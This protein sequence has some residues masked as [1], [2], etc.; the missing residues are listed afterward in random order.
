MLKKE[1]REM[2]V[3]KEDSGGMA[4]PEMERLL[5]QVWPFCSNLKSM[6]I[7]GSSSLKKMVKI[8]VAG[9]GRKEAR[10]GNWKCKGGRGLG[11]L[12][13]QHWVNTR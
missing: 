12:I 5:Q 11:E 9:G 1:K 7:K 10:E 6:E 3:D 13:I 2:T 4:A 8:I